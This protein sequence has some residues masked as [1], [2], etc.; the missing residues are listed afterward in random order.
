[1][2][3]II[4]QENAVKGRKGGS[5]AKLL[6]GDHLAPRDRNLLFRSSLG[7]LLRRANRHIPVT[8]SD[9][10]RLLPYVDPDPDEQ[11]VWHDR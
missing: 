8:A 11:G 5:P 2:G 9:L 3:T 4:Q 10:T 6:P 1:M 7:L